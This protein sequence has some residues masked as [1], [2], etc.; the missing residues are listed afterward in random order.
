MRNARNVLRAAVIAFYALLWVGGIVS[1][2]L[3]D[4]PPDDAGWTAP[5]FLLLAGALSLST[6][7]ARDAVRI[8]AAGCV[9]LLAEFAGVHTHFPFGEYRYTETLQPLVLGVPVVML[10]AWL[11]LIVY[12]RD[13]LG[14][15]QT[16]EGNRLALGALWL[17]AIDLVIDPLAAGPLDYWRWTHPGW[18]YG[19]PWTN[20]AGWLLV[21]FVAMAVAGRAPSRSRGGRA[22]GLSIVLFF[23]L[24]ALANGQYLAASIGLLLCGLDKAVYRSARKRFPETGS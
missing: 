1:Y 17:T 20:F 15:R 4:G 2:W 7:P 8:A 14:A 9:G 3:L 21:S 18:Y 16:G 23:A 13:A 10:C 12:V 24:T 5:V 11:V 19:I 6:L 22:V